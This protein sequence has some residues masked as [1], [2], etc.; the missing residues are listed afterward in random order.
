MKATKKHYLPGLTIIALMVL[1]ACD[2]T[3]V[4]TLGMETYYRV[5]DKA[6]EEI[7]AEVTG[8]RPLVRRAFIRVESSFIDKLNFGDSVLVVFQRDGDRLASAKVYSQPSLDDNAGNPALV[9][10]FEGQEKATS[11]G[12]VGFEFRVS[13]SEFGAT[14]FAEG[15]RKSVLV[16]FTVHDGE[17]RYHHLEIIREVDGNPM[18]RK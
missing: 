3:D 4:V 1:A 9:G 8:E 12:L 11:L 17:L 5:Y 15:L 10:G 18:V 7:H 13:E 14:A 16:H 2:R 6:L